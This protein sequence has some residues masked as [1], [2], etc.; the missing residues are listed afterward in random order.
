MGGSMKITKRQ[1][2]RIIRE[3]R[4]RLTK[5]RESRAD[6]TISDNEEAERRVFLADVEEQLEEL[7]MFVQMESQR[8]GGGFRGPGI[9]AQ[10]LK[11]MA[12]LIYEER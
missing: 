5:V 7:I 9:K 10:A 3:E 11:L 2:G 8:I 4:S 12:E 6:G 1:L